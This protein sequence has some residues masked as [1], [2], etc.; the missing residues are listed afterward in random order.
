MGVIPYGDYCKVA[1]YPSAEPSLSIHHTGILA[2]RHAI[3][4]RHLVAA[5]E[6]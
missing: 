6:R 3:Y 2:Y 5:H 1:L 4:Y